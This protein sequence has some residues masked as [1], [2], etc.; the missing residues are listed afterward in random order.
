MKKIIGS[1]L[2]LLSFSFANAQ[3]DTLQFYVD[4]S[5]NKIDEKMAT[6]YR[7]AI[8]QNTYWQVFDLFLLT[9][10]IQ[11]RGYYS[12]DSL[13]IKEGPFE[14][15][16]KTGKTSGKGSYSNGKYNGLW[17][18]WYEDGQL[19]DSVMYKE[20]AP[21]GESTGWYEDGKVMI[22]R[23]FDADGKGNGLYTK[24]YLSGKLRDSGYFENNKRNGIWTFF[25]DDETKASEIRYEK[26]SILGGINYD[27]KGRVQKDATSEVE[28]EF[29]GGEAA[30]NS[31]LSRRLS[32]LYNL[33]N[34][35]SYEGYCNIQFVIDTDGKTVSI[36]AIDHN[37]E[38]LAGAV[39]SIIQGSKKWNPAIQFNL[40]VKAWRKQRFVFKLE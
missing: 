10:K 11:M 32:E 20:G 40:P 36:E 26:D 3:S 16:S 29:K 23:N 19:R 34:A 21:V 33:K 5:G 38:L 6:Y 1:V 30:W 13:K 27:T 18:W 17:K 35:A 4:G 37:N 31:Y 12:D 28:A 25:R 14:Y 15:F 7:V 24:Y 2:L 8:R 39:I 9:D 22:K